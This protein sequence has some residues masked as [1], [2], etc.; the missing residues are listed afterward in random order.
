MNKRTSRL[1][2]FVTILVSSYVS[3]EDTCNYDNHPYARAGGGQT[4]D[5]KYK[6][7]PIGELIDVGDAQF[8]LVRM[9]FVDLETGDRYAITFPEKVTSIKAPPG[10][11][12]ANN[13]I[14]PS[15]NI[16]ENLYDDTGCSD[17]AVKG[18]VSHNK[19]I[20]V[21]SGGSVGVGYVN[22]KRMLRVSRNIGVFLSF[23]TKSTAVLVNIHLRKNT[24]VNC[25]NLKQELATGTMEGDWECPASIENYDHDLVE[26][27]DWN[28][29]SKPP[30][31]LLNQLDQL[32]DYVVV[33]AITE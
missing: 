17:V 8:V 4:V 25:E 3:A 26:H 33:E 30:E 2:F 13:I 16:E 10:F 5:Y 24:A 29:L 23:R 32:V 11:E 15:I 7:A 1:L 27:I 20:S 6:P 19:R 9:P 14:A 18:V 31:G 12:D 22:R 28:N 21:Q